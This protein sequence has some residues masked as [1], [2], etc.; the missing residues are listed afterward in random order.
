MNRYGISE[1]SI[2][3]IRKEPNDRSEMISQLLF[4]ETFQI[5]EELEKW[6]FIKK[7]F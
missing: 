2:V 4:G 7:Y 1:T 3:P 5:I 6:S